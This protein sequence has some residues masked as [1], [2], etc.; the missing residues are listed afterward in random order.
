MRQDGQRTDGV[1]HAIR[2]RIDGISHK[3]PN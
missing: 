3:M 2:D 1:P